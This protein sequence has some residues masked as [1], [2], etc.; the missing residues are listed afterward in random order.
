MQGLSLQ[1][2]IE[3]VGVFD[4]SLLCKIAFG[5]FKSLDEYNEKF[6]SDY[7]EICSCDVFFDKDANIKVN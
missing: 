7:G 1:E 2:M 3:S 6:I 5:L 4:E